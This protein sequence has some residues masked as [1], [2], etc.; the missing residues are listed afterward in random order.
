MTNRVDTEL[1]IPPFIDRT[2]VDSWLSQYNLLLG[3]FITDGYSTN[4]SK[5]LLWTYFVL[6]TF[7]TNVMFLNMLIAIMSDTFARITE[8][9]VKYGLKERTQLYAD[10]IYALKLN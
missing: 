5:K 3:N 6:A 7:F 9:K 10:Y 4:Q 2:A 1:L 8:H